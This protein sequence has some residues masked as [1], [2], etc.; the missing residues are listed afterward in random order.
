MIAAMEKKMHIIIAKQIKLLHREKR[1]KDI[2]L[3]WS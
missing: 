3:Y 1:N 2:S